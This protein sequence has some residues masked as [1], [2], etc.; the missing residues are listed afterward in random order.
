MPIPSLRISP[1]RE[2]CAVMGFR[3]Q[4]A[5]ECHT[6]DV[7][8]KDGDGPEVAFRRKNVRCRWVLSMLFQK[9]E[10][11]HD[12]FNQCLDKAM[13]AI[14][15]ERKFKRYRI[16]K[17]TGMCAPGNRRGAVF[18]YNTAVWPIS[19]KPP[20]VYGA[21]SGR[22]AAGAAWGNG[23]WTAGRIRAYAR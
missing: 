6:E 16:K 7:A 9:N 2:P 17:Q 13:D 18:W 14:D 5:V 8:A 4:W 12:S 19:L 15:Y 1:W 22:V 20:A 23:D 11:Y 3:R 10:L 21:K